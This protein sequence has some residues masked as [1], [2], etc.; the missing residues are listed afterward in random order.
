MEFVIKDKIAEIN[1]KASDK[2][3]IS[4]EESDAVRSR[5]NEK[6]READIDFRNKKNESMESASNAFLT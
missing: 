5:I 2:K 6:M 3:T 1:E 4:A